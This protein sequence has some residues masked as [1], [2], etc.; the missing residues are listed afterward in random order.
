MSTDIRHIWSG[1]HIQKPGVTLNAGRLTM[2]YENGSIRYIS[3]GENEII[4]M[5]YSAVRDKEW[6]TIKP[7]ITN[8][9][10]ERG[11]SS[12]KIVYRCLYKS[13]EVN[14]SARYLI[15]GQSDNK[16]SLSFEGEA[17]DT[18]EKC[19]IGFCVLHPVEN[20]SG[21]PCIITHS[22]Q[23]TETCIFPVEIDPLQ[24]FRD[25]N[26]MRWEANG[27]EFRLDFSGDIFETEDQR[28][29]TDT[30]YKTYCTPQ[31]LPSPS[32]IRKGEKINQKVILKVVRSFPE[33]KGP[34]VQQ[35]ITINPE[36]H[37]PLP[38]IGISRSTRDIPLTE[39]E[40]GTIKNI[41]FDHYRTDLHMYTSDWK[42][43]ADLAGKE[44]LEMGYPLE[45]ALFFDDGFLREVN[46]LIEWIS[47]CNP[48]ISVILLYHRTWLVTPLILTS[49]VTPLLKKAIPLLITGYGTN[50]NFAQ[51]NFDRPES[52]PGD[53]ICYS[54]QPQEHASD[55]T[56]LTE[57]LQA[58]LHTVESARQFSDGRGIWVSPVNIKRRFNAN[59][60]NY[61]TPHTEDSLPPQVDSRLMSLFG[62]CWTAGS[63]K[64]LCESGLSGAT[65]YET[66]GERG[67]IQG[68]LPSRWPD[69]F[70]SVPGMIFPAATVFK[71][72]LQ[73][74][75]LKVIKSSSSH[76]LKFDCLVLSD[77]KKTRIIAVNFTADRQ[78][79]SITGI[80]GHAG[81]RQLH[82]GN[83]P[84]AVSD[85]K[86]IDNSPCTRINLIENLLLEPFSISFINTEW[87]VNDI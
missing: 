37:L 64:Y 15:E 53:L 45:L 74:K 79:I 43:K 67:I 83:Y 31:S 71:F 13:R 73:D 5:I 24:P 29:W 9:W 66:A 42:K 19:R 54:V 77:G 27:T 50:A 51:I 76:P 3:A 75:F 33:K 80:P 56:T 20:C 52:A 63:L 41:G 59:V 8:E 28:N 65:Y 18:F 14:F 87:I 61:E 36:I 82:A 12:F 32:L 44:A 4:R 70:Q 39:N 10:I 55:N 21:K 6:L 72:L 85:L 46:D 30:S 17:L 34:A 81:L 23:S 60:E 86:W 57:N 62:G 7:V 68:D 16:I 11:S 48:R 47:S 69:R 35:T 2:L 38:K 25:I 49:L 78:N 22:D 84:D 58:Q 40:A 1:D 26:S